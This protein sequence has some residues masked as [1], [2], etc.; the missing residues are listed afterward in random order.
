MLKGFELPHC[1]KCDLYKLCKNP[2]MPPI[3][4][5]I[6]DI[7]ILGEGPSER[8][9]LMGKPF[10][11][12]SGEVLNAILEH[13]NMNPERIRFNNAVKCKVGRDGASD[14]QIDACRQSIHEDIKKTKP[15]VIIAMG[16]SA[17]KSLFGRSEP[18]IY[19]WR[20]WQIPFHDFNCW[21]VPVYPMSKIL[22]DGISDNKLQWTKGT[23]HA[24]TLRVLREDLSIVKD[25]INIPIS[26][27]RPFTI[28]KLLKFEEVLDFFNKAN[29]MD[30]FVFDYETLGLKPYFDYSCILSIS[31]TFD[32]DTV[33]TIPISY[34][35][36]ISKKKYWN[37]SQEQRIL[38]ELKRLLTNPISTK[39][40]HN[41]VFELEWSKAILGIDIVNP[42]DS[43][44]QKYILD[45]REGTNSLD[46]LA[47][48][49]FGVTWKTYPD[50][51]MSNL[52][53]LSIDELLEYNGKDSVFEYRL[54]K[55]QEKQLNKNKIL[56][57]CY[58]EQL[59]TG[60]TI[61][62]IQYDGACTNQESRENLLKDYKKERGRLEQELL[63]LDSIKEFREKYGKVPALKSNSK[64]I[65]TILFNIENLDPFKK[66]NK[67]NFS[68]DKEVLMTY[69]DKSRFC[70]LLLKFREYS[71]IEGKILKG[72]TECVFPDQKYHTNF[73]PVETGRLGSGSINLQNLDKRKHPEIR[74]IIIAPEGYVL[75][76]MDYS[77]LEARILAAVSNCRNF[78][79]MIKT[80]YDIHMAKAIEIWGEDFI[81]N[82]SE[83]DVKKLRYRAKNEF[84]F[85]SFYGAKPPATA[86]R[87][88]I[89]ELHAKQLLEKLWSDFPEILE[90]QQEVLKIY[91]KKRYVEIPPGR[92]RY[93]PLTTNKILN[94]PIQGASSSIVC[95]VMNILSRKGL[96]IYLNCHDELVV[97]VK[98][99]D[100]KHIAKE[101]QMVMEEKQY[102]FMRDVP[103]RV[104]GSVGLN[105]YDTISL[106]E[107]FG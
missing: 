71:G 1:T 18:G 67:G 66:T 75:I 36:Y 74:Q 33:Y 26:K 20:G 59:E 90:W 11:G 39:V 98:D 9:D 76:I 14:L 21:V 83:K 12:Q 73:Y 62:Q 30:F 8:D 78:I 72:Y 37:S 97:C 4:P 35:E 82:S 2:E 45:C 105:W 91:E 88:G 40:M 41:I 85:P 53:Q 17:I 25:L 89:T 65:P 15:R 106:K 7:Y 31:I 93:A 6:A 55:L 69:S 47:F 43:M 42:E 99:S 60:K 104:E 86:K 22:Q 5:E 34:Y 102:D 61:A 68:V 57:F 94:T 50:S 96:W 81:K 56:L 52:T 28:K 92:R 87:L 49:N 95:K 103:L 29:K 46:F 27:N 58:R 13:L 70:E 38:E 101:M 44:L 51:I 80:G 64:D 3:G 16:N 63:S 48:V 19:G 107:L 32:G 77:Q 23:N 54:Y 100:A 79:E 10:K 24:D 84:V